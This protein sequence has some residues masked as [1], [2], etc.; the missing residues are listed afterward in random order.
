[1][2]SINQQISSAFAIPLENQLLVVGP[3]IKQDICQDLVNELLT[4]G[5]INF[6]VG[7][8]TLSEGSLPLLDKIAATARRCRDARFEVAGHTDTSGDEQ[9]NKK[10]SKNRAQT[11]VEYLYNQGLDKS[12]FTAVGY[13]HEQPISDNSTP[14]GRAQNRRI[15][16]R[17]KDDSLLNQP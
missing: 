9:F 2:H 4:T 3:P 15:E 8:A 11:V 13:G 16:F 12:Q 10:L 5:K 17:L 14:D 7:Q 6:D 1:M